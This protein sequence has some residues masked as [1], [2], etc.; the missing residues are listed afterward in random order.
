V[1]EP[2][3][4]AAERLKVLAETTDGFAIARADLRIRG[5]GDLFGAQQHGVPV[6]RFADLLEDEDLLVRAQVEAR[7]LVERDPSSRARTTSRSR[8]T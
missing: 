2:G 7:A 5:Q 6:L 1:A 8:P 3:E 4:E